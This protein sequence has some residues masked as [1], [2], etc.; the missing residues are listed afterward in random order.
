VAVEIFDPFE[1]LSVDDRSVDR[2]VVAEYGPAGTV[3]LGLAL[4]NLEGRR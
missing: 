4:R 1:G 3:A 2:A